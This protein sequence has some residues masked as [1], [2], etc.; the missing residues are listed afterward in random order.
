M[1]TTFS[2]GFHRDS[3]NGVSTRKLQLK[4]ETLRQLTD[5]ELRRVGGGGVSSVS[6]SPSVHQSSGTSV[7]SPSTSIL[8]GTSANP[9]GG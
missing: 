6:L 4:K 8:S 1:Q 9:S 5:G 3:T 2:F 7:I